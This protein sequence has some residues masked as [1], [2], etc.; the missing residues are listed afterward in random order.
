MFEFNQPNTHYFTLVDAS[1]TRLASTTG[2]TARVSLDGGAFA[3]GGGTLSVVETNLFKYVG[4]AGDANGAIGCWKFDHAD[5]VTPE[6][7]TF[8]TSRD[9]FRALFRNPLIRRTFNGLAAANVEGMD[10]LSA[11]YLSLMGAEASPDLTIA[12]PQVNLTYAGD[13]TV[14]ATYDIHSAIS[15][16]MG[17]RPIGRFRDSNIVQRN[18]TGVTSNFKVDDALT[19]MVALVAGREAKSGTTYTR[20]QLGTIGSESV[21]QTFTLDSSTTPNLRNRT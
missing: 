8:R 16:Y 20:Y 12:T 6:T 9:I 15:D 11:A 10:A 18:L 1:G 21:L 2:V 5:A 19:C 3:D 4:A 14:I 7:L 17:D 13:A